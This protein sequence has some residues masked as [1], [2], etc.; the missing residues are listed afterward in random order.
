MNMTQCTAVRRSERSDLTENEIAWLAFWRAITA[1]MDPAPTLR[2]VQ[3]AQRLLRRT[4]GSQHQRRGL[5]SRC[6]STCTD[7]RKVY[8][9]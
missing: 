3:L 1:G 6:G 4:R 5:P 8:K 9:S 2:L 7:A